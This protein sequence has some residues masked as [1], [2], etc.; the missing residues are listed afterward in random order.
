MKLNRLEFGAG[1]VVLDDALIGVDVDDI[2]HVHL[3]HVAVGDRQRA[4]VFLGVEEDR[5]DL[6]AQTVAAVALV[7]HVGDVIAGPPQHRVGGGLAAGAGADHIADV[8][9]RMALGLER[10]DQLQRADFANFVGLDARTFHLQHRQA[11]QRDVGPAPGVGSGGEVVGVGFAGHLEYGD[12]DFLRHL[13]SAGEPFGLGP[14]LHDLLGVGVAGVGLGLDAVP[15]VEHQQGVRQRLGGGGGALGVVQQVDQRLDVVAAQHGAEQFGGAHPGNQRRLGLALGDGG[16]EGGLDVGGLI[17][18]GRHPV[19]NQFHQEVFLALGRILEQF[20]QIGG[21]LRAERQGGNAHGGAFGG[22]LAIV[23]EHG[24][25]PLMMVRLPRI[26][27]AD[28]VDLGWLERVHFRGGA[29]VPLQKTML[30]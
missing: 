24:K 5:C 12:G 21:L 3:G 19:G 30:L 8:G 13:G 2:A 10:F 18:A 14:G 29:R 4:G 6:A 16:Q 20:H 23:F 25:T 26:R 22:L 17:D 15:V 11:V 28:V 9:D 7:R 27:V 1:V